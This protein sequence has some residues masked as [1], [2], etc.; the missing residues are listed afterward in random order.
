MQ[1]YYWLS[2]KSTAYFS[3]K[4]TQFLSSLERFFSN[5]AKAVA[6]SWPG[7]PLKCVLHSFFDRKRRPGVKKKEKRW[8]SALLKWNCISKLLI[9][10]L[11]SFKI[12]YKTRHW[13]LCFVYF[14]WCY[15]I[16]I[17]IY[18]IVVIKLNIMRKKT[19]TAT[20]KYLYLLLNFKCH[21]QKKINYLI[22]DALLQVSICPQNVPFRMR[23][24]RVN[25]TVPKGQWLL[26]I[27]R[28]SIPSLEPFEA[29]LVDWMPNR[30]RKKPNWGQYRTVKTRN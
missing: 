14:Y 7:A 11:K 10:S 3:K 2:T 16:L 8:R 5:A 17:I 9:V 19:T 12:S 24:P 23:Y 26:A 22:T 1:L 30:N 28:L 13:Q 6:W 27:D 15:C 4:W 18:K 21:L 25:Q 29:E 20:Q